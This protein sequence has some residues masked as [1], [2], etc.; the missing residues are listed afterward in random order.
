MRGFLLGD[1]HAPLLRTFFQVV[2]LKLTAGTRLQL[3]GQGLGV[4]VV[5]Q[6]QRLARQQFIEAAKD[7]GMALLRRQCANVDGVVLNRSGSHFKV[8]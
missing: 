4:V 1:L 7:G 8:L 5:H 2:P 3:A 6:L